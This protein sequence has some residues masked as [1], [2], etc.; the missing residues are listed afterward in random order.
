[1][2][3]NDINLLI[4][5]ESADDA[6]PV[7]A[8][9]KRKGQLPFHLL[10]NTKDAFLAAL[11][12]QPWDAVIADYVLP[13]FSGREALHLIRKLGL[14][15]PFIMLSG[16]Y[17]E[18]EAVRMLKAGANDY[19]MKSNLARLA[20]ALDREILAARDRHRRQRAEDAMQFLAALVESSSEAIYGKNLDG[21]I[22]S[23][24][25][26]AER[27][28]GYSP[29][30][31][32][33]RPSAV[34]F[35]PQRQEETLEI[36]AAIRRGDV[37]GERVTERLHKTGRPIPVA[38]TISPVKNQAGR[39]IGASSIARDISRERQIETEREHFRQKFMA[40]SQELQTLTRLLPI[41]PNC[42]RVREDQSYWQEVESFFTGHRTWNFPPEM[43]L[44]CA[45]EYEPPLPL[46]N[47]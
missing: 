18:E 34:L 1:M 38:V 15:T 32:I 8:A 39:I 12:S 36:L 30:E 43:C 26:G 3:G 45:G 2:D 31:I 44:A 47:S 24:N 42:R 5:D 27:L 29:G 37:I 17:G 13:N 22:V 21:L 25:P 10:V 28:F 14:D 33:G 6:K 19:L 4:L 7:L 11:R 16:I 23:W 20:P 35:P 41:C 46:R 9:L 40:V